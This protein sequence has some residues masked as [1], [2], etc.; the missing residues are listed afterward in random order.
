MPH[1]ST[2]E[3]DI[4]LSTIYLEE[5]ILEINILKQEMADAEDS[6]CTMMEIGQILEEKMTSIVTKA[7]QDR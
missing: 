2:F 1:N 3:T 7:T 4:D 6:F 5:E